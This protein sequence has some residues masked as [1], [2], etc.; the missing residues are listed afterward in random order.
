MAG[1]KAKDSLAERMQS[2]LDGTGDPRE[3][4]REWEN[5]RSDCPVTALQGAGP[6][7]SREGVSLGNLT[8]AKA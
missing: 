6:V 1:L 2:F 3:A 4:G 5:K 8:P 7:T